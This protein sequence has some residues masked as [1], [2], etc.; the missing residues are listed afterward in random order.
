[1]SEAP[2]PSPRP[3]NPAAIAA[4]FVLLSL[5]WVLVVLVYVPRRAPAAQNAPPQNLPKELAWR[6]T[7]AS[8][9]AHLRELREK[10]ALETGTYRWIDQGAGVVGLPIERAMELVVREQGGAK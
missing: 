4:V 5:F 9:R 2:A 1:M 7:P 8:R 3:V 6:A 10:E